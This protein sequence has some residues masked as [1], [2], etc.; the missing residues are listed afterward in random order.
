[1]KKQHHINEYD[2]GAYFSMHDMNGDKKLD[3]LELKN[4]FGYHIGHKDTQVDTIINDAI[5]QSDEDKDGKL[6]FEEFLSAMK[7]ARAQEATEHAEKPSENHPHAQEHIEDGWNHADEYADEHYDWDLTDHEWEEE[8]HWQDA[9]KHGSSHQRAAHHGDA[10]GDYYE[11]ER[12]NDHHGSRYEHE[13]YDG[14]GDRYE[15]DYGYDS[16][17][18]E[19]EDSHWNNHPRSAGDGNRHVDDHEKHSREPHEAHY[20]H[21]ESHEN[22]RHPGHYQHVYRRHIEA[23]MNAHVNTKAYAAIPSKYRT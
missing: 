22:V 9:E 10:H 1:M 11:H 7:L 13:H 2:D 8:Q 15:H 17:D 18:Y 23:D 6:N 4:G 20:H 21:Y 16:H 3:A 19:H 14:H 12:E 5:K